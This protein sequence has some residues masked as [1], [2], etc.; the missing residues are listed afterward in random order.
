[1]RQQRNVMNEKSVM[2]CLNHPFLLRLHATMQDRDQ[3]YMLL[4]LVQG[5]ELWSLL[6]QRQ[7]ALAIG[8]CGGVSADAARFYAA[9]VVAALEEFAAN[10][11]AYRDLKVQ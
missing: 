1:M 3:L 7:G 5:G 4:E 11:I 9:C 10:D 8:P 2:A 6:Y